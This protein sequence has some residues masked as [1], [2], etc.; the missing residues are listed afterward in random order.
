MSNDNSTYGSSAIAA[1][2]E[3]QFLLANS[4]LQI[5]GFVTSLSGILGNFLC[6]L[7]STQLPVSNSAYLMAYLAAMDTLGGVTDGIDLMARYFGVLIE[8]ISVT[9]ILCSL[10]I[11]LKASFTVFL[12][13]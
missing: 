7:T 1:G 2:S 5:F 9:I 3:N 10:R 12:K 4:A 11:F 8:E 6:F 13:P